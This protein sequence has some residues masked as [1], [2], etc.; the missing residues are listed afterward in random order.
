MAAAENPRLRRPRKRRQ[1]HRVLIIHSACPA[2]EQWD[3]TVIRKALHSGGIGRFT[4]PVATTL[5]L[6]LTVQKYANSF[7]FYT[8][9]FSKTKPSSSII[10][11]TSSSSSYSLFLPCLDRQQTE[12]AE[13]QK[14][15]SPPHFETEIKQKSK[16]YLLVPQIVFY[17]TSNLVSIITTT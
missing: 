15:R 1:G 7:L 10:S 12:T 5:S 8:V 2:R 16:L 14:V 13:L 3:C 11:T 4:T 6:K 17:G 9:T